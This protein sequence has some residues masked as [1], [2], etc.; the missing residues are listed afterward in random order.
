MVSEDSVGVSEESRAPAGWYPDPWGLAS[1]RWWDGTAWTGYAGASDGPL[2]SARRRARGW[3]PPRDNHDGALRGGGIALAGFVAANVASLGLGLLAIA[4]GASVHSIEVIAAGQ[5][6]LWGGFFVACV[7][8]ARRQGYHSLAQLGLRRPTWGDLGIGSV[9][10][11][12]IRIATVI[13][14]AEVVR[15]FPH[16][17]LRRVTSLSRTLDVGGI[18]AVAIVL[19]VVIGAPF[20]EE[21]YFRGLVQSVMTRRWSARAAIFGQAGCFALVHYQLG[22]TWAQVAV[23]FATIGTMGLAL[24]TLRW[25]YQRLDPGMVAHAIFNAQAVI[26]LLTLA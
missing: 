26:L 17:S 2:S 6:G 9:A 16:Q 21:L 10:G 22:M 1:L 3:F 13:I 23:T 24:G 7:V 25:R 5:F 18:A 12:A 11:V 15:F 8:A 4:A 19:I 20:F 14:A